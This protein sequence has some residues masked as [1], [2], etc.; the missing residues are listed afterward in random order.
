MHEQE[1]DVSVRVWD[2]ADAVDGNVVF[3]GSLK[4]ESGVLRV[5]NALG[6]AVLA[7]PTAAGWTDVVIYTDAATEPTRVDVVVA[8]A[9]SS[10]F[11]NGGTP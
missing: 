7:V 6:A 4:L 9:V 11:A 10:G 5:S 2:D 3:R 1:G 8:T